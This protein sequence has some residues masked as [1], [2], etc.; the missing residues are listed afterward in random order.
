MMKS[1]VVPLA[2]L[3][4]LYSSLGAAAE[5]PELRERAS[6][7]SDAI[8]S[9]GKESFLGTKPTRKVTV[10]SGSSRSRSGW[11]LGTEL[12]SSELR[13][14][15]QVWSTLSAVLIFP[16]LPCSVRWGLFFWCFQVQF[17]RLSYK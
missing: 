15:F 14:V 1:H 7:T 12:E 13:A 17:G 5:T 8:K 6:A 11:T 10:A 9:G 2:L 3:A 4:C 16:S